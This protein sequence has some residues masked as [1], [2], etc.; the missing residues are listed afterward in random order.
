MGALTTTT[1]GD[2]LPQPDDSSVQRVDEAL[3]KAWLALQQ[4]H[5]TIAAQVTMD[6]GTQE[7]V[8]TYREFQDE[9]DTQA[10]LQKTLIR[11][12]SFKLLLKR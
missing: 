11:K 6:A 10:W 4:D 2:R 1:R 12:K 7:R 9:A 5:F 8:K 3:R